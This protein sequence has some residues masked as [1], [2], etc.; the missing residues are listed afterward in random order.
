MVTHT[1]PAAF[2]FPVRRLLVHK[3]VLFAAFTLLSVPAVPAAADVLYATTPIGSSARTSDYGQADQSGFRTFD[4]FTLTSSGSVQTVTWL[5]F[6]FGLPVPAAAPAPDVTTWDI[7]FHAD[8]AGT[9]GAALLAQSFPAAAV[10]STFLGTAGYV[11]GDT[12]NVS[13]YQ[14]SMT[15][16]VSFAATAGQ[17]YWLSVLSQSPA[18]T[19]F[20]AWQGASGGNSSSFQQV[21]G[22]NMNVVSAG[23]VAADRAFTLEGTVPEPTS[24]VLFGTAAVG[25]ALRR[26]RRNA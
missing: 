14:H 9:P 16:P 2:L 5:G 13:Y 6:W 11:A 17:T 23:N 15:L 21:L 10:T 26:R 19:P 22:A 8:A 24:L 1:S 7:A 18:F 12:Y 3:S 4:A 20:F 25:L